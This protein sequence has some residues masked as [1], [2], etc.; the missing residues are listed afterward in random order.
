MT[1]RKSRTIVF[2]TIGSALLLFLGGCDCPCH[3]R[4]LYRDPRVHHS[5]LGEFFSP[6]LLSLL[7]IQAGRHCGKIG[8]NS[9][10]R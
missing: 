7:H 9:E 8:E 1:I 4:I 10:A 5:L 6:A 3:M 2:V